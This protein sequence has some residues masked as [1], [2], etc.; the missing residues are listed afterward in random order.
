MSIPMTTWLSRGRSSRCGFTN[1]WV[2]VLRA[3][4]AVLTSD[5]LDAT[6]LRSATSRV[7]VPSAPVVT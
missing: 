7:T 3:P 2:R 6:P 5:T 1:A 4:H